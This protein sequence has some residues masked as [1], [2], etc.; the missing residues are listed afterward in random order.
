[1]F[2]KGELNLKF[3]S[4]SMNPPLQLLEISEKVLFFSLLL[5]R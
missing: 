4:L 5:F 1:M 2:I 3:K